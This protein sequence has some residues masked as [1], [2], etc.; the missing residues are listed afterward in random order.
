MLRK[1]FNHPNE[2]IQNILKS[3]VTALGIQNDADEL[4]S[5]KVIFLSVIIYS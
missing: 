2:I 1:F 4:I 3:N 5:G